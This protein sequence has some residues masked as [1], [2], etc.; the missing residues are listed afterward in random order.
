LVN[1]HFYE[2]KE[3]ERERGR[4][5]ER[6]RE[7][8]RQQRAKSTFFVYHPVLKGCVEVQET[9]SVPTHPQLTF[10]HP[11]LTEETA[12]ECIGFTRVASL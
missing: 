9:R 8:E 4:E 12:P 3:R 5:R 11:K 10:S 2:E 6:E 1:D 7:R